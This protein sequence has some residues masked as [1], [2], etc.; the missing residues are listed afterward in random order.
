MNLPRDSELEFN[1]DYR[2]LSLTFLDLADSH[3]GA[4]E[5]PLNFRTNV[6]AGSGAAR[7]QELESQHLLYRGLFRCSC[8]RWVGHSALLINLKKEMT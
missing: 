4:L 7:G 1:T 8:S 6:R 2:I 3:H 5:N